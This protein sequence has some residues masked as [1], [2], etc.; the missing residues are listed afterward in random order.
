MDEVIASVAPALQ[1][2]IGAYRRE[3][4]LPG[5]AAGLASSDGLRW[6]HATGFADLAS[7]R[8]PDERML[9]RVASITKTITATAVLQLRDDGR[10][11][12]DD[13]AVRFIPE[14]ERVAD[15]HG[16]IEDLTIRR[17]LMHTS[18]LQ[19]ELNLAGS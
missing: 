11:R 8:R 12:L 17:L 5:I 6:W 16:P 9:Y 18:G 4:R 13:P 7:G 19:G 14:L 1:A 2:K 15:P 3:H 10:F